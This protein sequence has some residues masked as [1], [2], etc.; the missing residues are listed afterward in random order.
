[1]DTI[2]AQL[3]SSDS[4]EEGFDGDYDI[5]IVGGGPAGGRFDS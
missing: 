1:M 4:N 5:F 2:V 3:Q